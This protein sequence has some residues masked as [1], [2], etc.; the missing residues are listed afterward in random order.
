MALATVNSIEFSDGTRELV[1]NSGTV[2]FVGPNNAGKSQALRDLQDTIRNRSHEGVVLQCNYSEASAAE[3]ERWVVTNLPLSNR[4]GVNGFDIPDWG[5]APLY[6]LQTQ[7]SSLRGQGLNM[8]LPLAVLHADGSSRLTAGSSQ[9]SF[10]RSTETPTHPLQLA[11]TDPELEEAI[12]KA[13]QQAFGLGISVDRY[14]GSTIALRVGERPE[15]THVGGIPTKHYID[16]LHSLPKLEEQGDGVRS[17]MGLLL[18][19]L[20]GTQSVLLIDEPEAFLHPPQAK[21]LG[22]LLTSSKQ[23]VQT[24]V[25]THSADV[26]L[27]ALESDAPVTI[28]RI[29]REG[30]INKASTLSQEDVGN[31]WSDPLLR[32][33]NVLDGLFHDVVVLCEGDGDCRYYS[34]LLDHLEETTKSEETR[35]SPQVLFTHS[36]GKSRLH[37]LASALRTAGIPVI[38]VADF[39]VLRNEV[40][41]RRIIEALDG[42]FDS[43][44]TDL[45]VLASALTSTPR[46]IRREDAKEKLNGILDS[47]ATATLGKKDLDR[48]RT[49]LKTESGWDKAKAG[50]LAALPQ[51][52]PARAGE[53]LLEGLRKIGLLVV[54]VG[55]LE[56]FATT[57]NGKGPSWVSE[58]LSQR[59]HE[60]PGTDAAAFAEA[61]R[62]AT[63][64]ASGLT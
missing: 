5:I 61:L 45:R 28:I 41:I 47:G 2:I 57:V 62:S 15:F 48:L 52:D 53:R 51:G 1:P 6:E 17:Y 50:G 27:G 35:Q 33:S 13:C 44:H 8:F 9:V 60:T 7:W 14:G 40:D 24:F 25:S 23:G 22:R 3:F 64:L 34:A 12:D 19:V 32:Y 63:R 30:N 18:H 54:P 11:Y 4:H 49:E 21:R 29:T 42:D 38:V 56:R 20:G 58:V 39:D 31:L 59:L 16:S 36:G 37:S 55:E 10:D 43:F 26:V 46:A